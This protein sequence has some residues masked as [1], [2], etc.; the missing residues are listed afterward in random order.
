FKVTIKFA[1]KPDLHHLRQFLQSRQL[2][3]PQETIQALDVALRGDPSDKYTVVGRSF[4]HLTLGRPGELADGIIYWKGYYQ[5]LRLIQLGLSLNIDVSARAFYETIR[6]SDFVF[7][8]FNVRDD[9]RPL[10][11]QVRLQLKKNLKGVKVA[12]SHLQNTRTYKITGISTEP[13]NKLMFTLDDKMTQISVAAYFQD[14]YK[15]KLR[16][17]TWPALQAGNAA[18][19]IYLPMEVCTIV[20][21]QRY[22]KKLNERQVTNL[23]RATYQRPNDREESIWRIVKQNKYSDHELVQDFGISVVNNLTMVDARVLPPP[24]VFF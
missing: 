24:V 2:D 13:L 1:S 20:E 3:A 8:N 23:L 16:Y 6:V 14:K 19:P 22:S 9:L 5:S 10:H 21:G 15:I 17:V 12:C 18:K 7:K 4:F 11:D